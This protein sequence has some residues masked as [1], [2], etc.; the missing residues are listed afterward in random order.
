MNLQ[1]PSVMS[2]G[3]SSNNLYQKTFGSDGDS[4]KSKKP[5]RNHVTQN[6]DLIDQF[7]YEFI[8]DSNSNVFR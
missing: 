1:E 7:G 8:I 4:E 5:Y 3:M 6:S 2:V